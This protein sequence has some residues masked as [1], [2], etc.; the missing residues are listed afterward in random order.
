MTKETERRIRAWILAA[1]YAALIFGVSS[2]PQGPLSMHCIRV[3]D[4]LA[5]MAEYAGFGLFLSVAFR[6]SVKNP[7]SWVLTVVVV[8]VGA[9][10]GALD[11][12]YQSTVPGRELDVLDWTADVIGLVL[13]NSFAMLLWIRAGRKRQA[14][15]DAS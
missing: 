1:G 7:R 5:H 13:G 15:A 11:E 8:L 12:L 9:I 6:M 4:K 2:I 14:N 3:S 10:T